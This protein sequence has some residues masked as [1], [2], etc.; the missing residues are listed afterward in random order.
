MDVKTIKAGQKGF[1]RLWKR[2]KANHRVDMDQ[3]GSAAEV[4]RICGT[5]TAQE[6]LNPSMPA[7]I[8]YWS[9]NGHFLIIR[10]SK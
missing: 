1:E 5:N 4:D 7:T 9:K 8:T 2:V 10:D 6:V 3:Y